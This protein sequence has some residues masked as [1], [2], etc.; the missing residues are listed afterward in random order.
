MRVYLSQYI[1][2]TERAMFPK[3]ILSALAATSVLCSVAVSFG[4]QS[5]MPATY[6]PAVAQQSSMPASYLPAGDATDQRLTQMQQEIDALRTRLDSQA[7]C[8][9][10][11]ADPCAYSR[12]GGLYAGAAIV[13]AKPFFKESFQ[14]TSQ[15][16][17][18]G[19]MDLLGFDF[20]YDAT[21]R[22][23][24]GYSR[25]DG[26]GIRATYW[27]FDHSPQ[28]RT[29]V[30]DGMTVFTAQAMTVIFP[31]YIVASTPGD[32]LAIAGG[33]DVQT[34]DVEGTQDLRLGS[35]LLKASAG[36]R[37]ASLVQDSSASVTSGGVTTQQLSWSRTYRGLGPSVGVDLRRPLGSWGLEFVGAGRGALL[38]GKKDLSRQ[39][40]PPS[41]PNPPSVE[42]TDA[43]DVTG[44]G[45][46]EIGAQWVR[47]L[48]R[49]GQLF[50]RG[51]YEGQFWSEAGAP[52]LTFL[53]FEGF[54]LTCGLTY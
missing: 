18:T 7:T 26:L 10:C 13:F 45:E 21:P 37:F 43:H 29:F 6:L 48:A 35:F 42:L 30:A 33:L 14:A 19:Q 27:R 15:S 11:P 46:L 49:G 9:G 44:C 32:T 40:S 24:L 28:P 51:T 52:T 36:L 25:D 47:D 12:D 39:V 16:L 3:W 2:Q 1:H 22:V 41:F 4:Q 23:W 38:Y 34:L 50:I 20:T 54:G 5:P 8:G 53:G 31:A 17:V